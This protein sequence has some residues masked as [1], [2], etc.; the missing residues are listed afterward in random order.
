MKKTA[1][2]IASAVQQVGR[3][4]D[5]IA[6][7]YARRHPARAAAETAL[8]R[9]R[10]TIRKEFGRSDVTPGTPETLFRASRTR[11]GAL[12]RL[13]VGGVIT[14]DQLQAAAEIAGVAERLGA[15]VQVRTTSVETRVDV[16]RSYDS[17]FFESLGTVRREVAYRRWCA[18]LPEPGVVLAMIVEDIGVRAAAQRWRMRDA[19]AKRLL[20]HA[21]DRW[22]DT[23]GTV[24]KEIDA[25]D[26]LAAHAGLSG[27]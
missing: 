13:F 25:A 8:G 23:I 18:A 11:Q 6:A 7:D 17:A 2:A 20:G 4:S 12:A 3:R 26:V 14:L 1:G 10:R 24:A 16:S 9:E 22:F 27:G 19:R 5:K 21:L 15:D